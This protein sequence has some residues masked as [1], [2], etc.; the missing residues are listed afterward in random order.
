MLGWRDAAP[1][2]KEPPPT[3]RHS[4]ARLSALVREHPLLFF[5]LV[6]LVLYGNT[7]GHRYALDD[8]IV[9]LENTFTQQGIRGIPAIFAHDTFVG[10]L[11]LNKRLVQGG[12]YRPL[13]VATFAIEQ[14]FFGE[15]PHISHLINILLYGLTGWLLYIVLRRLFRDRGSPATW[16]GVP[17]LAALVFM[18]HPVHTEVV[19]NIKG[20]DEILALLLAVVSLLMQLR[21]VETGR[22]LELIGSGFTFFVALLAKESALPFLVLFPLTLY[23]FTRATRRDHLWL[24]LSCLAAAAAYLW[25]REAATGQPAVAGRPEILND[26]FLFATAGQRYATILYSLLR[27]LGLLA[28][29]HPLTHDYYFNHIPLVGWANPW[30]VLSL[31]V[32]V[33]LGALAIAGLRKRALPAFGALFYL[34]ALSVASNL[35]VSVGVIMSERFLYIP[36]VGFAIGVGHALERGIGRTSTAGRPV[37]ARLWG[38]GTLAI[39]IAYTWVTVARNPAWRDS[40]TLFT[41]DVRTSPNSAKAQT[42]AGGVLIEAADEAR[43][44]RDK[45]RL[46][47]EASAHLRRAVEIYPGD[48]EA[49]LM[50]GNAYAK[51]EGTR[52]RAIGC[53]EK[54]IASWPR[55]I[56][57]YTNLGVVSLQERDY[58][59][60]IGAYRALL[61]QDPQN[62]DGWYGLG[63]AYEESS[64]PDSALDAYQHA[65]AVNPGRADA[66][67]KLGTAYGRFRGD[68][69]K[70]AFYLTEAIRKGGREEWVFDNLGVALGSMHRY[71]QAL[72]TFHQGLQ[73]HPRSRKLELSLATTYHLLGDDLQARTHEARARALGAEIT[74]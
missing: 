57:A 43:D 65:V 26:P 27:Y 51:Q 74:P 50:L 28:F 69:E 70:A 49:W 48:G 37:S 14:Q 21:Y 54:A 53:Y 44:Q 31:I 41:I 46:L 72:Q 18:V 9:I 38:F 34:I 1:P 32:H 7:L 19:A 22:P 66:L 58:P 52:T 36:S 73:Y 6:A 25:L 35:I 56:Q 10:F 63:L 30:V 20:R 16:I 24:S 5:L 42:G 12:R 3:P 60:A 11:G 67:A 40:L 13:S 71:Q 33:A 64:R 55:L 17:L 8:G 68:F 2:M 23:F 39:V 62:A 61:E 47:E 15:S 4:W 59:R 29:P 45:R